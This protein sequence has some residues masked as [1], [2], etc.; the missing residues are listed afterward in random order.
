MAGT[1]TLEADTARSRIWKFPSGIK[2]AS[3]PTRIAGLDELRGIAVLMVMVAHGVGLTNF[4]PR[5]F[6]NFGTLGV[7]LFFSISGY[8]ITR[9]LLDTVQKQESLSVFY[10]RRVL[11][12]WPLMIA[13]LLFSAIVHP[14]TGYAVIYNL[15]LMNNYAAANGLELAYRTD[16]MWSLAIEEQFYLLWPLGVLVLGR[17]GLPYALG[18][19]IF[20]GFVFGTRII[21]TGEDNISRA[22]HGAMQYIALGCC[23]AL[24]R[25]GLLAAVLAVASFLILFI[26]FHAPSNFDWVWFIAGLACFPVTYFTV[27]VAPLIRFAPLAHI[28]RLCYGLYLI[29]TFVSAYLFELMPKGLA[30]FGTYFA[31]SYVLAFA[32]LYLF[33]APILN[34]RRFF[35]RSA[36]ARAALWLTIATTVLTAL[37]FYISFSGEKPKTTRETAFECTGMFQSQKTANGELPSEYSAMM[38]RLEGMG[39]E[40]QERVDGSNAFAAVWLQRTEDQKRLMAETCRRQF[41]LN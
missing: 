40:F 33:E 6:N 7:Y 23:I 13:V 17:R 32:S 39:I 41:G 36:K 30:A 15:L 22:T 24:G 37:V 38:G 12:I 16:V 2:S 14:E 28:G 29:H 10:V 31:I 4:L 27:H 25:T 8:L 3:I 34:T 9:I 11:R 26:A 18:L 21:D 19:L 20:V 5:W 1:T 35:E